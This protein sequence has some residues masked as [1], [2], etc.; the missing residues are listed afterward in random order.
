M[1]K[2]SDALRSAGKAAADEYATRKAEKEA[3]GPGDQ[4]TVAGISVQCPHCGHVRFTN[5][6]TVV[7][8]RL[9][10]QEKATALVCGKCTHILWFRDDP[11]RVEDGDPP[12]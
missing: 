11:D 10:P 4:Y 5:I 12:A 9:E 8:G 3:R 1:G 2:I 7:Q 6:A